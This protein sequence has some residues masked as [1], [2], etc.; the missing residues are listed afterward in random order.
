[1]YF[2]IWI[3]LIINIINCLFSL[4]TVNINSF[5][6][7]YSIFNSIIFLQLSVGSKRTSEL[8]AMRC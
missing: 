7:K 5:S 6:F 8:F 4:N 1:M 3:Y 2:Y